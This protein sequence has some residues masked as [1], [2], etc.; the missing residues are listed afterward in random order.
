[1][2]SLVTKKVECYTCFELVRKVIVCHK[3]TF[4][5]CVLCYQTYIKTDIIH[6]RCMK[7]GYMWSYTETL[8]LFPD[9]FMKELNK[10]RE[11]ILF[12]LQKSLLPAISETHLENYKIYKLFKKSLYLRDE[13]LDNRIS[14]LME[15]IRKYEVT[16]E[17]IRNNIKL[18]ES[19][20]EKLGYSSLTYPIRAIDIRH[21]TDKIKTSKALGGYTINCLSNCILYWSK[22]TKFY[23]HFTIAK[24]IYKD[25]RFDDNISSYSK[26]SYKNV[27][28]KKCDNGYLSY[29]YICMSCN[30][31]FCR[32]CEEE[33]T[34]EEQEN[35]KKQL[36][37]KLQNLR[38]TIEEDNLDKVINECLA[39]SINNSEN[40]DNSDN[41]ENLDNSENLEYDKVIKKKS[42]AKID[43][44]NKKLGLHVCNSDA[45]KN[46]KLIRKECVSC[47]S[48][49]TNIQKIFGC[50][51][52]WCTKCNT[53]FD[54][55]SGHILSLK[56]FHNPHYMEY[57]KSLKEKKNNNNSNDQSNPEL[58]N[59]EMLC[60][61]SGLANYENCIST[62]L[63]N[64]LRELHTHL[65]NMFSNVDQKI[66]LVSLKYLDNEISLDKFKTKLQRLD[67]L[68]NKNQEIRDLNTIFILQTTEIYNTY[69]NE[70]E[71]LI[72]R[73]N[74]VI[75]EN[76]IYRDE[77]SKKYKNI[78]GYIKHIKPITNPENH[79]IHDGN[80][81]CNSVFIASV[82]CFTCA[83]N[84][85][86]YKDYLKHYESAPIVSNIFNSEFN[87]KLCAKQLGLM[88]YPQSYVVV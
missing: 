55:V 67:K 13:Y 56:N 16:G 57:L 22:D 11:E 46:I 19:A 29:D 69:F 82:K 30:T 74:R 48:C 34:P 2:S 42:K 49:H 59:I 63:R 4:E 54:W 10:V 9:K 75:R 3:C 21:E 33:I 20:F 87:V 50:N 44:E 6:P 78:I 28:C 76:N 66:M 86:T 62:S 12:S 32:N 71:E 64:G 7:C 31:A 43:K 26:N 61:A 83:A 5:S 68:R 80:P 81:V 35:A 18:L 17:V 65:N 73:L 27:P 1:M 79:R 52:M 24:D 58:D 41:L 8:S 53:P 70:E 15:P 47:P 45:L 72:I 85:K 40:L 77:L 51:Q 37:L 14:R 84:M 25:M 88:P 23:K 38:L 60:D 39:A 36:E